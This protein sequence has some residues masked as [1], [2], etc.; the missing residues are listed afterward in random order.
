M[1]QSKKF[2]ITSFFLA[3]LVVINSYFLFKHNDVIEKKYYANEALFASLDTHTKELEKNAVVTA[4]NTHY[5]GSYVQTIG[6]VLVTKGQ[7]VAVMDELAIF[8]TDELDRIHDE[9]AAYEKELNELNSILSNLEKEGGSSSPSTSTDSTTLGNAE[10]WNLNLSVELGIEQNTP[11]AEGIAIIERHIAETQRQIDILNSASD[12]ISMNNALTTPVEGIV[13]DIIVDG[14]SI[15]FVIQ[16]TPKKIVVYVD[17]EEWKYVDE[18]QQATVVINEGEDD[19]LIV[20]GTVIQKQEIPARESI[21]YDVMRKHE[22]INEDETI[23]EVSIE[24]FDFLLDTPIGQFAKATIV[25]NEVADSYEVPADWVVKYNVDDVSDEHIYTIGYDGLTRLEPV[26]VEFEHQTEIVNGW[27]EE[28]VVEEEPIEEELPEEE[29]VPVEEETTETTEPRII[30]VDLEDASA[31]KETDK[32]DLQNAKVITAPLEN[33]MIF[34]SGD[35]K[36]IMAPVFRPY[37]LQT[38]KWDRVGEV[39]WRDVLFFMLP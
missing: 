13:E 36:N 3:V 30:T 16:T 4:G 22:K 38:Y 27:L 25:T 6:E 12:Q 37:P 39:T 10:F 33:N 28:E 34:L 21:A 35:E 20:D 5:V 24:P 26:T 32:A 31:E 14:E 23:Y 11:T 9:I 1:L 29:E 18:N 2:K 8:K 7:S 15:T 17:S 19:E